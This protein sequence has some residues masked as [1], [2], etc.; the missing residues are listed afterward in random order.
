MLINLSDLGE[1][2]PKLSKDFML[3][4]IQLLFDKLIIVHEHL[5]ISQDLYQFYIKFLFLNELHLHYFLC[6]F[7][8]FFLPLKK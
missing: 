1:A 4:Q 6:F 5:R 2:F 3:L 8:F 7:F